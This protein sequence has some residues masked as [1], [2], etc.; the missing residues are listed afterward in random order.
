MYEIKQHRDESPSDFLNRLGEAAVKYTTLD[1]DSAN[2]EA[3]LTL[4]FMGQATNDIRRKL[5]KLRF[6]T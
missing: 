4:L 2:W 6:R 1:P 3:H 5:Q